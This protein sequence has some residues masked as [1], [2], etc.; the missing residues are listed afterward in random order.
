MG[1]EP[2]QT[3]VKSWGWVR[4][5]GRGLLSAVFPAR[6]VGCDRVL[7]AG[8]VGRDGVCAGCEALIPWL[9]HAVGTGHIV[10]PR[11]ERLTAV[12]R[13]EGPMM[14]AIHGLKYEGRTDR[15]RALATLLWQS[16]TANGPY[17]V[18]VAVPLA[19]DRL[20]ER[21]Y[22]QS[23]L[24]AQAVA[25]EARVR[26][27]VDWVRRV[28]G[29]PSQVGLEAA[30]RLANVRGAFAVTPRG[31]AGFRDRRVLLIDDVLTTGATLHECA[32][33]IHHAHPARLDAA[34]IAVA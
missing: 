22:N 16:V 32:R 18:I 24:L 4:A 23:Q 6:C 28:R 2:Q 1:S 12:C 8:R 25:G 7:V 10:A 3:I 13:F 26:A 21:G 11:W 19:A 30:A 14:S 20:R 29:T 9:G 15:A 31:A 5:V 27:P 34:V 17:D 33:A